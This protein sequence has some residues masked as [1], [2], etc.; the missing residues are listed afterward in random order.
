[1]NATGERDV[2]DEIPRCPAC[3]QAMPYPLAFFPFDV[4][5]SACGSLPWCSVARQD[6]LL[7][8]DVLPGRTPDTEDIA[9][10]VETHVRASG[11]Q[12][13]L[14]DLAELDMLDSSLVG[15]LFFCISASDPPGT[16]S[17]CAG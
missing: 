10:F 17:C 7:I 16:V 14:C 9:W 12:A 2:L 8:L 6:G 1:M 3:G 11:R 15:R 5:C 4:P 13:V